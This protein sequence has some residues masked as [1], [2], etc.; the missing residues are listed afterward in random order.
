MQES[1]TLAHH[2]LTGS[3]T[4]TYHFPSHSTLQKASSKLLQDYWIEV[5]LIQSQNRR[6]LRDANDLEIPD[7]FCFEQQMRGS[8]NRDV[9]ITVV[10]LTTYSVRQELPKHSSLR[11]GLLKFGHGQ[12]TAA[13]VRSETR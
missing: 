13:K 1:H 11:A 4:Q 8:P 3:T 6:N 10:Q 9:C 7:R 12:K 5:R 2:S